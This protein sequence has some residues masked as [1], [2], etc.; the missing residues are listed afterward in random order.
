MAG[1]PRSAV[2]PLLLALLAL[3]PRPAAA[4]QVPVGSLL[5]EYG[6][7]LQ[8]A[9]LTAPTS[10]GARPRAEAELTAGLRS[11]PPSPWV[12]ALQ[13]R[14]VPLD[15]GRGVR[16][17]AE[18]V[19]VRW[20][21]NTDRPWGTNDG[22]VW[23]GKGTTVA[24]TGG[25]SLRAGRLSAS[26]QPV[27]AWAQNADFALSPF[28]PSRPSL[29][30]SP[31]AYPTLSP[32]QTLDAP[33]R[34]GQDPYGVVDLGQSF[35]RVDWRGAAVGLSTENQW[36][37]PGVRNSILMSNHAAGMPH[38]FVGTSRPARLG[39]V[40]T[41]DARW[42]WGQLRESAWFDSVSANDRRFF[43]GIVVSVS[44]AALPGLQLGAT[45]AFVSDWDRRGSDFFRIFGAFQKVKQV[46]GASPVGDD[47]QDQLA[48]VFVRWVFPASRLEV[49]GEWAKGDHSWD[50]R[51]LMLE[52]EHA[53]GYQLGLQK[54]LGNPEDV[55]WRLTGEVTLLG[56]PRTGQ[57]RAPELSYFY[58]H[59]IIRQG[60]TQRGQVL[61]AGIG[62]GSNQQYVGLDRYARWGRVGIAVQRTGYDNDRFIRQPQPYRN[63]MEVEP[64]LLA[65]ALVF[66]GAWDLEASLAVAKLLNQHYIL[67]NDRTNVNL[68]FGVRRHWAARQR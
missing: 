48:S 16:W 10:L 21:G 19:G 59:H 33:Q 26:V 38:L 68:T 30:L 20:F 29:P 17:R 24:A 1:T 34:F 27:F 64:A 2:L 55:I 45:R 46:S 8:V 42:S 57:V 51:D 53:S 5:D 62:P 12:A 60:Y 54:V 14:V 15:S 11:A 9:G 58:V 7:L 66:R 3:P 25:L 36:W 18:P 49:Y 23:Q 67:R 63:Y 35:V 47:L 22:A 13:A 61:G 44:P 52:P 56:A 32:S 6:R 31:Y 4:Q 50:L 65:N 28:S 39:R 43:T 41:L 40:A 37:G